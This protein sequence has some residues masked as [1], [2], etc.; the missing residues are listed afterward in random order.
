MRTE[1]EI[2]ELIEEHL[3]TKRALHLGRRNRHAGAIDALRWVLE[4]S[5][6]SEQKVKVEE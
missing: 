3:E 5:Q 4:E 1:E 2:L 6:G